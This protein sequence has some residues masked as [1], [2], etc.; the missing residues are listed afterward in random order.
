MFVEARNAQLSDLQ[1]F[2]GGVTGRE[3]SVTRDIGQ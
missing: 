1:V 3:L 2:L